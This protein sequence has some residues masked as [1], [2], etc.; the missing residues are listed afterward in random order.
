M[1]DIAANAAA[2]RMGKWTPATLKV[3]RQH[4]T[5]HSSFELKGEIISTGCIC[6]KLGM[7][8]TYDAGN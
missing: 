2:I 8:H 3:L 6:N 1:P 7:S 4:G 5:E